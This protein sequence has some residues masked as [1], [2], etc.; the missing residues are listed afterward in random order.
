MILSFGG[1]YGSK[2]VIIEEVTDVGVNVGVSKK[3]TNG[4]GR[5]DGVDRWAV[6]S[7][8]SRA[9]R[10]VLVK[11]REVRGINFLRCITQF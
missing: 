8:L 9:W 11:T 10:H 4:D 3:G 1:I 2:M 6:R 5:D 7:F